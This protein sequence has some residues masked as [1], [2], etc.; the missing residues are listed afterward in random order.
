MNEEHAVQLWHVLAT[1]GGGA[2]G[3]IALVWRMWVKP[4]HDAKVDLE[5]WK[6]QVEARLENGEK[7]F[8]RHS[9]ADKTVL[10][11]LTA[12]EERLRGVENKLARLEERAH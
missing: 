7:T 10:A 6:A 4:I 12:I 9:D 3:T 8:S 5:R 2:L 11:K 1:G